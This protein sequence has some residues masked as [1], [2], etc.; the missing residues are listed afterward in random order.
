MKS[1]G[2]HPK[3]TGAQ[4][5]LIFQGK[6][7]KA[8]SVLGYTVSSH[9]RGRRFKSSPAYH[10]KL[11]EDRMLSLTGGILF[12]FDWILGVQIVSIKNL[13]PSKFSW[14]IKNVYGSSHVVGSQV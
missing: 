2:K 12:F 9:G 1:Q 5:L 11:N 7:E 4:R 14:G 13:I 8:A 10:V 3:S 6:Y